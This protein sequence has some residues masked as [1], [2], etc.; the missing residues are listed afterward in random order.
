MTVPFRQSF[1]HDSRS[2]LSSQFVPSSGKESNYLSWPLAD[3]SAF[4][5]IFCDIKSPTS[6]EI[7]SSCDTHSKNWKLFLLVPF[8]ET[9]VSVGKRK[10]RNKHSLEGKK[11][12][13]DRTCHFLSKYLFKRSNWPFLPIPGYRSQSYMSENLFGKLLWLVYRRLFPIKGYSALR[14][15]KG[16]IV[17]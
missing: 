16:E 4:A 12:E 3:S 7:G 10:F 6:S 17:I 5:Y 1:L 14:D 13:I 11:K 2:I 9:S 15:L 8:V